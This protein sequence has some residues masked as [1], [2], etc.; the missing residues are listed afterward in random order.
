MYA[1][2]RNMR[3]PRSCEECDFQY[4]NPLYDEDICCPTGECISKHHRRED[5]PICGECVKEYMDYVMPGGR[6]N[7]DLYNAR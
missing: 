2:I 4:H 5:C 3:I 1:I 6:P 7:W